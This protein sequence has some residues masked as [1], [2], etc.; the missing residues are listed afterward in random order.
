MHIASRILSSG[1]TVTLP[2]IRAAGCKQT[3]GSCRN[4]DA[5]YTPSVSGFCPDEREKNLSSGQR[6]KFAGITKGVR[7]AG[8]YRGGGEEEDEELW[9][10]QARKNGRSLAE[11]RK[12][13]IRDIC[14]SPFFF[15]FPR[16]LAPPNEVDH[17]NFNLTTENPGTGDHRGTD[18]L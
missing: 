1:L 12:V 10:G 13:F 16:A 2:S 9:G 15:S 14:L 3:A 18:Q 4:E 8:G 6:R 5:I 7:K 17:G 11:L